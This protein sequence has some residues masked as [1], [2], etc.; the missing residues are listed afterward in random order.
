MWREE[1]CTVMV[2]LRMGE[3]VNADDEKEV[4][5]GRLAYHLIF[6]HGDIVGFKHKGALK[7]AEEMINQSWWEEFINEGKA[8]SAD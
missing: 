3:A 6:E 7:K 1:I 5:R 2:R 4:M 8:A